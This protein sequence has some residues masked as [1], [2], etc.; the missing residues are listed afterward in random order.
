MGTVLSLHVIKKICMW[1]ESLL[2]LK[3]LH[4]C[5]YI[6]AMAIYIVSHLI[7]ESLHVD[8]WAIVLRYNVR[9]VF[10]GQLIIPL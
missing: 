3:Y 6:F 8:L 5:M 4:G 7:K 1:N 2:G 10:S 9:S